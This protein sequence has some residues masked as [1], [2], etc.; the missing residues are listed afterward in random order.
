[1]KKK[2]LLILMPLLFFGCAHTEK[3]VETA[4]FPPLPQPPRLQ[5][6]LSIS[7]E[8]DI[9]GKKAGALQEWLIGKRPG[10]KRIARPQSIA[11][12]RGKIYILD[13]TYKKVLI[14]DL[15]KKEMDFIKDEREGALGDP[16]G[17]WVTENDVKYVADGQRKQIVVFGKDNKFLKTYGEKDQLKRPMDVA[18]YKDSIYVADF[19]AHTVVLLDEKTGKIVQTIGG[20]GWEE[21][22]FNRPTHVTVDPDGNLYVND[23]FNFRIQKFDPNG[24]FLK[25]YGYQ[26]DTLGG[27]A[28]PKGIAVDRGGL[29]YAVDAAFENA[30]IFDDKTTDLLLFFGGYGPHT[31]S[32]YLPS[33]LHIDYE[34]VEYFNKYADKDFKVKYLVLVGNLLGDRKVN[35]YGFGEWIGAPLPV[36]ERKPIPS[37][38]PAGKEGNEGKK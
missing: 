22:K 18:V 9:G 6:L 20:P 28:R 10:R 17:L 29:I 13:R 12:S 15:V 7:S 26:G 8:E 38:P 34:N 2:W 11:A 14:L 36:V 4:F 3:K 21:G 19:L 37:E 31:G 32:M 33:S 5:F 35:V 30:Q 1:M 23:S 24:K 25:T 16:F 27:F